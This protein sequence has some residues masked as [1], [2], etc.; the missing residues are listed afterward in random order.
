MYF[1]SKYRFLFV[2]PTLIFVFF[3][4][5][6]SAY[7]IHSLVDLKSVKVLE[8]YSPPMPTRVLDVKGR[9]IGQFYAEKRE[10]ATYEEL[11]I[12]LIKATLITEDER[13]FEHYGFN[14][15]RILKAFYHNVIQM[16]TAQGGSTITIQLSKLLFLHHRQTL[17]RKIQELWYAIQIERLYTKKEILLF[18][19]NQIN[20]GHGCYGVKAAA[21]FFFNK[22]LSELTIAECTLLAGIPKS[23]TH[24]SPLRN[25]RPSMK[26]H[27]TVFL[28]LCRAGYLSTSEYQ[29]SYNN[30]WFE[31]S[32]VVRS[33][34][35]TVSQLENNEAP[36]FIEYIRGRL[37]KTIGKKALYKEG[38]TVHTTLDLDHQKI[39]RREL[40]KTL[41][42]Q[43]KLQ[44]NKEK[45]IKN[46]MNYSVYDQL[47][48][49]SQ[50]FGL[51]KI[52]IYDAKTSSRGNHLLL[53]KIHEQVK[54]LSLL[55]GQDNLFNVL[56]MSKLGDKINLNERAQ[57]AL[58]SINPNT[59][60]I[61]A[62]IGGSG[63]NYNNQLNRVFLAKRQ[64]GSLMKPFVYA[65]GIDTR[66]I[67]AATMITDSPIAFGDTYDDMYMPQNYSGKFSGNII[68]RDALR[69][70]VNVAAVK[71]LH[72]TGI[73]VV[74]DYSARMFR[75]IT[76]ADVEEKFPNNLSMGLGSGSFA[77]IDIATAYAVLA[78]QGREVI[79]MT[80]RYIT[81]RYGEVYTNF[82]NNQN[83]NYRQLLDPATAYIINQVLKGVFEPGGT[84]YNRDRLS[85]FGHKKNSAGKTGTTSNWKDAWFAGYNKYLVTVV[86][87][88]Y[89]S[90]KSLGNKRSGGSIAAPIWIN[91]NKEALRNKKTIA[92]VKPN[93]VVPRIISKDSGLLASPFSQSTYEEFFIKGTEPAEFC[94]RHKEHFQEGLNFSK[95]YGVK[96]KKKSK[97]IK[98][99]MNLV[100]ENSSTRE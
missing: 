11:P 44:P 60:Y 98:N 48:V 6:F 17:K 43:D 57:G 13:F 35:S 55:T 14:V 79:P 94:Q 53:E 82:E 2:Y 47:D 42:Q 27:K 52:H 30:F 92:F 16:R 15:W 75:S 89:D 49:L 51:N 56:H 7:V 58:V 26:R 46:Y 36:Y 91:F 88:G 93:N 40:S 22:G 24:Y 85:D 23:P 76:S 72:Q 12:W 84:A 90:N 34:Q 50:L 41:K 29:K 83:R 37:E 66:T 87:L 100:N 96:N 74:R 59:G 86:W 39:A 80:I 73:S 20:Y 10:L 18:Y 28:G 3:F 97:D 19:F 54:L 38:L 31:Y 9:L 32:S 77:P 61:T 5:I 1:K 70:S 69:K 65:A 95:Q 64:I 33:R 21:R 99:F 81:D 45:I 62:M 71:V 67:T 4:G 68:A 8:R 78:N 63:F 25:I